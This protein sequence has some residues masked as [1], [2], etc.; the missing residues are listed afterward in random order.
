[1]TIP[2]DIQKK[3]IIFKNGLDDML[4]SYGFKSD[5]HFRNYLKVNHKKLSAMYHGATYAIDN[6]FSPLLGMGVETYHQ[7]INECTQCNTI[8]RLQTFV[9]E[10]F[11]NTIELHTEDRLQPHECTDCGFNTVPKATII[12]YIDDVRCLAR[13]KGQEQLLEKME[14]K[15]TRALLDYL[16]G[17]STVDD[18]LRRSL[19]RVGTY[20]VYSLWLYVPYSF[21]G[22]PVEIPI[23]VQVTTKDFHIENEEEL[24][25]DL[26]K[27]MLTRKREL[28]ERLLSQTDDIK[29]PARL[30]KLPEDII[31]MRI[32]TDDLAESSRIVVKLKER[33]KHKVRK[34]T[35]HI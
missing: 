16:F 17:E 19:P 10:G 22:V 28:Y 4:R 31:A 23:E 27:K 32:L 24:P 12:D 5:D 25:H 8:S 18:Y 7:Q 29:S 21:N 33:Y 30:P 34:N 20:K 11:I 1:M 3:A 14:R 13:I 6:I 35:L 26:Y 2:D 9:G 15:Y